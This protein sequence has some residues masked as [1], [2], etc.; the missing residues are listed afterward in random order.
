MSYIAYLLS[1]R[2]SLP[3]SVGR[4]AV[5]PNNDCPTALLRISTV[6][7]VAL[8]CSR[9]HTWINYMQ[10]FFQF[11]LSIDRSDFRPLKARN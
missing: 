6:I 4:L 8:N 3:V 7:K 10:Y 5:C 11:L 9:V 1:T 2:H